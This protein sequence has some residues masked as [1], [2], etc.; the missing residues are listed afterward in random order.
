MQS[1]YKGDSSEVVDQQWALEPIYVGEA[2]THRWSLPRL[3]TEA[4]RAQAAAE[5]NLMLGA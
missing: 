5:I 4:P 3:E 2:Y 1:F